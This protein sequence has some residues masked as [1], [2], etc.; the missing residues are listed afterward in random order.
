MY[1]HISRIRFERQLRPVAR[2]GNGSRWSPE[3]GS[4][5]IHEIEPPFTVRRKAPIGEISERLRSIGRRVRHGS[6]GGSTTKNIVAVILAG[7]DCT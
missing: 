1:L 3:M 7:I 2:V 6:L 5:T 4:R